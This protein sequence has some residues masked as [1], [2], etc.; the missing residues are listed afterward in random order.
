L[1]APGAKALASMANDH[2]PKQDGEG[3]K[4]NDDRRE[5]PGRT[6]GQA[7]GKREKRGDDRREEPGRTPGQ[8]EG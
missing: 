4:E 5:E 2:D 8:A 6:P 3:R 1:G 7:E